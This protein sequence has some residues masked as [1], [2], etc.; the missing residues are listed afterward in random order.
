MGDFAPGDVTT[1]GIYETYIYTGEPA[2]LTVSGVEI[3]T[4]EPSSFALLAVGFTGLALGSLRRRQ[5][6]A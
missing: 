5:T 3:S 6:A 1:D 2:T 4:P